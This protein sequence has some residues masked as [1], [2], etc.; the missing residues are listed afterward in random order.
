M[1]IQ[2]FLPWHTTLIPIS[3]IIIKMKIV[4]SAE[5][6]MDCNSMLLSRAECFENT[7]SRGR[8]V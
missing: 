6:F 4:P 7:N 8:S 3:N 1:G 5:K 2:S